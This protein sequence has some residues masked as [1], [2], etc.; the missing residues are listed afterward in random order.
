MARD[1]PVLRGELDRIDDAIHDLLIARAEIVQEVAGL[2]KA[3]F[4]PGREA[5]ILAR[6]FARNRAPLRPEAIYRIWREIFASSLAMQTDFSVAVAGPE[7]AELA[8]AHFGASVPLQD[9]KG[10]Q[11]ALAAL[12][13]GAANVAVLPGLSELDPGLLRGFSVVA[14]LPFW[15]AASE[16]ADALVI[17][18]SAP[19]PSGN[20]CSLVAIGNSI[21][22]I[23][24]FL[25]AGDPQLLALGPDAMLLGAYAVPVAGENS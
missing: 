16:T 25:A 15:R 1:L 20:D 9:C 6:L 12:S 5:S 22:E 17:S 10:V 14:R 18:D 4:R 13:S 8:R 21:E 3:A 7:L 24:A 19:D 11:P 2:R 23:E